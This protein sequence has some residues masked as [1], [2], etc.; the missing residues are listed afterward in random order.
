VRA[1][2]LAASLAGAAPAAA[3]EPGYRAARTSASAESLL[4]VDGAGWQAAERIQWGPERYRTDFRALWSEAGLFVRFDATDPDPWH[5]LS[6][7]DERLWEEEVVELFLQPAGAPGAYAEVEINPANVAC[8]LWISGPPQL[9]GKAWDYAGLESRVHER[10]DP[11]G[12]VAGWTAIAFLPWS[13]LAASPAGKSLTLPPRSGD[14]WRFNVFRIERPGGKDHPERDA[15]FLA[16]S[17]TGK[18]TFHVP[19]AFRELTFLE[20]D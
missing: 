8:D 4:A 11:A 15:L 10:R 19:D 18:P 6:R 13:G 14:R 16:W 20:P 2:L 17:P 1:L 7:R 12:R 3:T 9:S 5:T